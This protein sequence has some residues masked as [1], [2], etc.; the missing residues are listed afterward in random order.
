[1][2]QKGTEIWESLFL[3]PSFGGRLESIDYRGQINH[4]SRVRR[5]GKFHT[6]KTVEE[7]GNN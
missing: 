5:R 2:K 1:M 4:I 6:T 3:F 7:D